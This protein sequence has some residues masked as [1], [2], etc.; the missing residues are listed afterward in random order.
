VRRHT[1]L[2]PADPVDLAPEILAGLAAFDPADFAVAIVDVPGRA[3][4]VTRTFYEDLRK[5][6]DAAG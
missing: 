1:K 5:R 6:T 3:V 2:P 4:V